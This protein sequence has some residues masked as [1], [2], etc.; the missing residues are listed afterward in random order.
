MVSIRVGRLCLLSVRSTPGGVT[1]EPILLA[2]AC[3]VA[4]ASISPLAH[5]FIKTMI[6]SNVQTVLA[7]EMGNGPGVSLRSTARLSLFK[8]S[9]LWTG[10]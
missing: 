4:K 2:S 6:S 10:L 1:P 5:E 3:P 8:P 9:G 7:K